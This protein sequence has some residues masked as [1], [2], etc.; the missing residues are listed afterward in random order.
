MIKSIPF[1]Y[2]KAAASHPGAPGGPAAQPSE[3]H[4]LPDVVVPSVQ[5]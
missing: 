2:L 5:L 1:I 4:R 3:L